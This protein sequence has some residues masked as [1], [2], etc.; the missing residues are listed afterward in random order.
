MNKNLIIVG[1][2]LALGVAFYLYQ[3]EKNTTT[4][5]MGGAK[6]EIQE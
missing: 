4:I 1:L 3:Q 6:I 5:D 2:V